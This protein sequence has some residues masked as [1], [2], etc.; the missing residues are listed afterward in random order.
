M[1][2]LFA[3]LP[4]MPWILFFSRYAGPFNLLMFSLKVST[5]VPLIATSARLSFEATYLKSSQ[6]S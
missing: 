4:Y 2:I 1:P 6:R 5:V 3:G